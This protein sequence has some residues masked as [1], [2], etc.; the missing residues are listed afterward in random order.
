MT[1]GYL[2]ATFRVSK[3]GFKQALHEVG[4]LGVR[5]WLT[6]SGIGAWCL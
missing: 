5:L 6:Y 2:A 3:G 1:K 4:D